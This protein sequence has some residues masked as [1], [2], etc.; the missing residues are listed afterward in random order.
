MKLNRTLNFVLLATVVAGLFLMTGSEV[1]AQAQ[2]PAR[3]SRINDFATVVDERTRQRLE[4]L[5]ENFQRKTD[6]QFDVATVQSTAG[7]KIF[8]FS[9]QMA[10]DWNVGAP[11]SPRKSLL[12]VIAINEKTA[13][14]QYSKGIRRDLP[15]G[16]L[17]DIAQRLQVLLTENQ[18]NLGVS[19]AV[20]HLISAFGKKL[21]FKLEELD[22]APTPVETTAAEVATQP[23]SGPGESQPEIKA[24]RKRQVTTLK[25]A[26]D[27]AEVSKPVDK[28]TASPE[29]STSMTDAD[30]SED[31]ELTLTLPLAERIIK[32]KEFIATHPN[33]KSKSRATELL[34]SAH[35]SLGDQQLG[36]GDINGGLQQLL[37]AIEAAPIDASEK[38]YAGVI[39]QI[40]LNLYLRNERIAAF[41]AAQSIEAKFGADPRRLL[42]LANFYL[43]IELGDEAVRLAAKAVSLAPDLAEA[44]YTLGLSL[45]ISMR[46]DE[47]V[48]E[49][50]RAIELDANLRLARRSLADLSRATGKPEAAL[51]FY[52]EQLA[53]EPRDKAARAGVVLSLLD[54]GRKEEGEKEL[55][56]ALQED[57]RNVT[58]L[59]GAAYWFVAHNDSKR[60]LELA[61]QAVNIEPRYTWSQVALAR[62]LIGE[63]QPLHAE[64]AMRF[65]R[66]YGKF[67][68]L[69]YELASTLASV[70][71]YEEA[72]EVLMP[73]FSLKD[74]EI[75]ARLGGRNY[76]K[77]PNFIELLAPERRASIFQFTVA[78]TPANANLL[79]ALLA[80]SIAAKQMEDPQTA[81]SDRL[82]AAGKEFARGEDSMRVYRQLFVAA[83]LLRLGK[84]LETVH[85]L[86]EAARGSVNDGI[87][88]PAVTVAVQADELRDIRARAIA[89]GGTP[90]IPEAPRN[91]LANILRGRIEDLV[92]WTLFNQ[93]KSAEAIEPLRRAVS[94]LPEGTPTW[95]AA[96]W[97]LGAALEQAGTKDEALDYYI[98]SYKSGVPDKVRR[99]MI[100]Q[101]YIK[102]KGST[103]GL[104]ERLG[105]IAVSSDSS[106]LANNI[107]STPAAPVTSEGT[108]EATP[109]SSST[110]AAPDVPAEKTV[111]PAETPQPTPEATPAPTPAETQS[112]P[113]ASPSPSPNTTPSET[114]PPTP[115]PTPTPA[116]E[117]AEPAPA[118]S[119]SPTQETPRRSG[120]AEPSLTDLPA[121]PPVRTRT[122]LKLN[123]RIKD[124]AGV[125]IANVVV[126]LISPGGSVL[127]ATTGEE[128]NFSFTVSPSEKAFRVLPS[129]E[130][131]SFTP[132]DKTLI[133]LTDDVK[134]ID[135]VGTPPATP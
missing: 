61:K 109:E 110:T 94:I 100:E 62:A 108:K 51:A 101:L 1:S 90:D 126:V 53:A 70:G 34:V 102:V 93:E 104:D 80:F 24:S 26:N 27:P 29:E 73:T 22:V 128:G 72:A 130:G 8:D 33:S 23:V 65:A 123:G 63:K 11:N 98:K 45:H 46:L 76:S 40:P 127:A 96:T 114:P 10:R 86:T 99:S 116:S 44:H 32:L 5:L 64:R 118:T 14:T 103:T 121:N 3:V 20:E 74:G 31:V 15:E 75:E 42:G 117:S 105:T 95:T 48:A 50:K 12:L 81:D 85:E 78:D 59:A 2:S 120:N 55:E 89:G 97:H 16:V 56:A 106:V 17:G 35:A 135:F 112:A 13:Y 82:I 41:K 18:F 69:E 7:Q 132:I 111:T 9:Y 19:A 67:P 52:R 125:G 60:G 87:E 129:K 71:L 83:R 39:S 92:G 30:E 77:A 37:L 84:G 91:V 79:K 38:L 6:I 131:F 133:V 134:D 124:G 68:T 115:E 113:E 47:A 107:T 21:A 36:G 28:P 119:S 66:Q 58:L 54:L 25:V 57:A 43:G 122:T 88:T 4:N 49:Y